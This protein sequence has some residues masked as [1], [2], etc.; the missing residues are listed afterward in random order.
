MAEPEQK[1]SV[2][3]T[4]VF[5]DLG[6]E[7]VLLD[8]ESGEYFAVDGTGKRIW[9][10]LAEGKTQSQVVGVIATEYEVNEDVARQDLE[11]FVAELLGRGLLRPVVPP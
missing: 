8:L 3:P 9:D 11:K 6:D 5:Q 1:F 7:T 2:P 10:C 4:V